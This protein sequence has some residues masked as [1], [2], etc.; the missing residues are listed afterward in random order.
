[1]TF[2]NAAHIRT[3]VAPGLSTRCTRTVTFL[4]PADAEA[5]PTTCHVP[6]GSES[7]SPI[8][9]CVGKTR[10]VLGGSGGGIPGSGGWTD[11]DFW[12]F[13]SGLGLAIQ[14]HAPSLAQSHRMLRAAPYFRI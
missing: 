7:W 10:V 1:V 3:S 5:R 6:V 8:W 4:P 14:D 13:F 9:S 12:R 2:S 11:L